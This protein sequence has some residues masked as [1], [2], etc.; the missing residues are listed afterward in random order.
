MVGRIN[1][2]LLKDSSSIVMITSQTLTKW[3]YI[4]FI[5]LRWSK[6][7]TGERRD[8][9]LCNTHHKR[10]LSH[11]ICQSEHCAFNPCVALTFAIDKCKVASIISKFKPIKTLWSRSFP[12]NPCFACH[13][14]ASMASQPGDLERAGERAGVKTRQMTSFNFVFFLCFSLC[15]SVDRLLM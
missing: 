8:N 7:S 13:A 3:S 9:I 5:H 11:F 14:A 2:Q 12:S 10:A 15:L 1:H 4:C 6:G